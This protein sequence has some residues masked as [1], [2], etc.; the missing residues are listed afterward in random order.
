ML[1]FW[2]L[3][4][5]YTG[6][7]AYMP[8][9]F[10]SFE[11]WPVYARWCCCWWDTRSTCR[12]FYPLPCILSIQ[13][14]NNPYPASPSAGLCLTCASLCLQW[15]VIYSADR[16]SLSFT[17]WGFFCFFFFFLL[18]DYLT[19]LGRWFISITW[20]CL[21]KWNAWRKD[22]SRSVAWY[23]DISWDIFYGHGKEHTNLKYS[24]I[25]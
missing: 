16:P 2:T 15:K 21:W 7:R 3:P 12:Q 13:L 17:F 6:D 9:H 4:T 24:S 23:V 25:L 20:E 8:L 18:N 1:W 10:S 22:V 11:W 14:H 19:V 5:V